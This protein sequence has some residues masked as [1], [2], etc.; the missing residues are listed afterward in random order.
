[1]LKAR[2]K[3]NAPA[4]EAKPEPLAE[5][6]IRSFK[7]TKL[8]AEAKKDRSGVDL[9]SPLNTATRTVN[10]FVCC[11]RGLGQIWFLDRN[12]VIMT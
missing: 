7:I 3:G 8:D 4:A 11:S 12:R 1:M 2:W 9:E 5:G 6:Q 10:R